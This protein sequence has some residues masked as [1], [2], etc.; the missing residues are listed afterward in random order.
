MRGFLDIWGLVDMCVELFC[1][2]QA[3]SCVQ[4]CEKKEAHN[5]VVGSQ[6]EECKQKSNIAHDLEAAPFLRTTSWHTFLNR[7]NFALAT[8]CAFFERRTAL[9]LAL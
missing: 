7:L 1:C 5:S 3:D 9:T 2:T 6:A 4:R 8:A